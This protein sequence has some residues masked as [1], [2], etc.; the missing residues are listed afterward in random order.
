[1]PASRRAMRVVVVL[2]CVVPFPAQAQRFGAQLSAEALAVGA[3]PR[4]EFGLGRSGRFAKSFLATSLEAFVRDCHPSNCV[5]TDFNANFGMPMFA[6]GMGPYIGIGLGVR[7]VPRNIEPVLNLLGGVRN[8]DLLAE[9]RINNETMVLT[10][11]FL[12]AGQR[13]E[14]GHP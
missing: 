8:A 6:S 5:S 13:R 3:G 11:G 12:F 4:V 2:L 10:L 1:M 9:V 7:E 14:Q